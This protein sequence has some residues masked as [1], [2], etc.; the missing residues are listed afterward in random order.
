MEGREVKSIRRSEEEC[1]LRTSGVY[2]LVAVPANGVHITVRNPS[3]FATP[4]MHT[5]CRRSRIQ[6]AVPQLD[7]ERPCCKGAPFKIRKRTTDHLARGVTGSKCYSFSVQPPHIY[8][9]LSPAAMFQQCLAMTRARSTTISVELLEY[10]ASPNHCRQAIAVNGR[11]AVPQLAATP[12]PAPSHGFLVASFVES[13]Q[14]PLSPSLYISR[15]I[16]DWFHLPA[17]PLDNTS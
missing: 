14:L 2:L 1:R 15:D 12:L 4:R 13:I 3:H 9:T 17:Y 16:V 10:K 6:V 5:H 7:V 8:C 11:L